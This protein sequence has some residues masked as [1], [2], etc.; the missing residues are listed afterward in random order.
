MK[1][2]ADENFPLDSYKAL[3]EEGLDI[4]SV[5]EVK[6][7]LSDEE[8]LS[9]AFKEGRTLLTFGKITVITRS[10]VRQRSL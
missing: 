5:L 1:F 10:T 4:K 2:L 7:G 8:V 6:A 9:L 3:K